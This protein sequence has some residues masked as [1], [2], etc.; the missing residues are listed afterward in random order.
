ML[1]NL[2]GITSRKTQGGLVSHFGEEIRNLSAEPEGGYR[3]YWAIRQ[4]FFFSR[5]T[6]NN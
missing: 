5:M 6:T 1:L 3:I 4:A 2:F